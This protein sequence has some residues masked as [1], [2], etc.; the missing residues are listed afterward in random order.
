M[1]AISISGVRSPATAVRDRRTRARQ[2]RE[3]RTALPFMLPGLLLV[4]VFVVYPL[5]RGLQMSLYH[6]N[7]V[8]PDQSQFIGPDNFVRALTQDPIFWT[9]VRNTVLYAVITVPAQMGIGLGAALLLN[10]ATRGRA[11]FR[12]LYY[13]PVVTSWLV[14]SYV[15]AYLFSDGPGPVN[16][17]LV[18]TLHILPAPLDWVHD[19]LASA[20]VPITLLGIWKGIGWN[21]VIFLAALQSIPI[22]LTE[23]ASVD[24]AGAWQRF[25]RI[26]L[27]LLRPAVIFVSIMLLIGAFNVFISVYLLTGGGPEGSTEVWLSYMWNQAFSYLDFGYGTAIGLLMGVA[28]MTIGFAQR[29]ILRGSGED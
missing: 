10:A 5:A 6:W 25:R 26:T 19:S 27:P 23:A 9:A 3:L 21:M 24:G 4:L 7:L 14:V 28:V 8:A 11:F 2:L 15:F 13:L 22:D 17:L 29:R 12:A 20:E 18:N 16:N 1:R